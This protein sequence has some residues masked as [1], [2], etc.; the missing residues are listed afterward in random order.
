MP[1]LCRPVAVEV[2]KADEHEI[3]GYVRNHQL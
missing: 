3:K 1:T 2:D